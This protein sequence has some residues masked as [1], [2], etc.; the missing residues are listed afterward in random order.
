M[1]TQIRNVVSQTALCL[2]PYQCNFRKMANDQAAKC[3]N[4]T[5]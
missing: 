4:Y 3:N 2:L 1:M 5:M